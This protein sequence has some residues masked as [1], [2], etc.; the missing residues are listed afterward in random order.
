M[1]KFIRIPIVL[2]IFSVLALLSLSAC[3]RPSSNTPRYPFIMN[4]NENAVLLIDRIQKSELAY[5]TKTW[6]VTDRM[7][8]DY[9]IYADNPLYNYYTIGHSSQNNFSIFSLVDQR[10]SIELSLPAHEAIFPLAFSEDYLFFL[11]TQ[12]NVM[13]KTIV[14]YDPTAHSLIEYK[15]LQG[16]I[17]FGALCDKTLYYTVFTE[18][19]HSYTLYKVD[20]TDPDAQPQL[21]QEGMNRGE[22]YAQGSKLFLT[23]NKFIYSGSTKF[24][25]EELNYFIGEK[26]LLQYVDNGKSDDA[27]VI[28]TETGDTVKK[29][30]NILGVSVVDNE[31]ILYCQGAIERFQYK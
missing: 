10:I 4:G 5:D 20:C 27:V 14:R 26:Y 15:N 8:P 16:M 6:E 1:R 9:T 30:S 19:G 22:I 28:N 18:V 29:A 3:A 31:I 21:V 23:D 25:K 11:K 24:K 2:S 13:N 7:N 12:D 17:S